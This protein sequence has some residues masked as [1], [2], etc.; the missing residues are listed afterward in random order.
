M[1]NLHYF[2]YFSPQFYDLLPD[3]Y[4][5]IEEPGD[6]EIIKKKKI[7]GIARKKD[8]S[9]K[10]N[11]KKEIIPIKELGDEDEITE[12]KNEPIKGKKKS[13]SETRDFFMSVKT[14]RK[15]VKPDENRK[16]STVQTISN[17]SINTVKITRK[18]VFLVMYIYF[19][20]KCYIL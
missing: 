8:G 10:G 4:A 5:D 15:K 17:R 7:V 6:A 12:N 13:I 3:Y 1:V 11:K 18:T 9:K 16:I 20:A 14:S 2:F 19:L